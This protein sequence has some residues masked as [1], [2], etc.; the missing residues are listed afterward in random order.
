[1]DLR[2]IFNV[3]R[4]GSAIVTKRGSAFYNSWYEQRLPF[5]KVIFNN[6]VEILTDIC[7]DV[8]YVNSRTITASLF[9]DFKRFF[10]VWG[11]AVM[12]HLFY[13]GFEVIGFSKRM[14][15][16]GLCRLRIL[17]TDEYNS[18]QD[19]LGNTIVY[20]NDI[21]TD[22]FVMKSST[23]EIFKTSDYA[24][25]RPW[26]VYLD[27]CMNASNT[28]A[29]RLGSILIMS[30]QAT[31]AN[32]GIVSRQQREAMENYIQENYGSL[33]TQKQILLLG[34]AMRTEVVSLS[35]M[36]S[37]IQEKVR[38]AILAICDRVKVPANQVAMID[39]NSGRS[40][41]N[42]G[43]IREGDYAKYQSFERLLYQTFG[44]LAEAMGLDVTYT[45]HNKP[46]QGL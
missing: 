8:E 16:D 46:M 28:S 33:S 24:L 13:N 21:D 10:D 40:L 11:K 20:A 9:L 18:T 29:S 35:D 5:S 30:P 2:T 34:Q 12:M 6:I 1:M 7:N 3:F 22:V 15:E 19:R 32:M 38:M 23:F 45:I 41:A 31:S 42:G 4:R 43:E 44:V 37:K 39:A 17:N 36:D 14:R 27:N 25:L 26:L